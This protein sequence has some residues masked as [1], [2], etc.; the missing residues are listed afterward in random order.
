MKKSNVNR[1]RLGGLAALAI[2][3]FV[4]AAVAPVAAV[5]WGQGGVN[6]DTYVNITNTPPRFAYQLPDGYYFNMTNV[7]AGSKAIHIADSPAT[8]NNLGQST[9]TPDTTGTFYVTDTGGRGAQDDIVLLV[10]VNG[11]SNA[12][13]NFQID[14]TSSGFTWIPTTTGKAPTSSGDVS[15]TDS[16]VSQTFTS[17]NYLKYGGNDVFQTWKF[18]PT[19]NYPTFDGQDAEVFKFMLIDLKVG[20]IGNKTSYYTTLAHNGTVKVD[21]T[22]RNLTTGDT[23]AFNIYAY[24]NQTVQGLGINWFNPTSGTGISGWVVQPE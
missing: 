24:N 6:N 12:L 15:Q 16:A 17:A 10:A 9:Y 14:I 19:A 21:Y 11:S 1:I 22:I 23:A 13:N 5:E 4:A 7:T 3:L 2:L 20:V 8:N 18:A